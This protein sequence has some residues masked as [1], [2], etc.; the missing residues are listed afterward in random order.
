METTSILINLFDPVVPNETLQLDQPSGAFQPA[1]TCFD[2]PDRLDRSKWFRCVGGIC[3]LSEKVVSFAKVA[4]PDVALQIQCSNCF[5]SV[6]SRWKW[7][8][9]LENYIFWCRRR[10]TGVVADNW[11][12]R[13]CPWLVVGD[14]PP[15]NDSV[16]EQDFCARRRRVMNCRLCGGRHICPHGRQSCQ[17]SIC[18]V[19]SPGP[20]SVTAA[21]NNTALW[22]RDL[23][24]V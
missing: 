20:Q 13:K 17:C 3:Y 14:F 12:K 10:V 6:K 8:Q 9:G 23:T 22:L 2:D 15:I 5:V 24:E 16:A 4:K 19:Q 7:K 1:Q 11:V 18:K 21:K